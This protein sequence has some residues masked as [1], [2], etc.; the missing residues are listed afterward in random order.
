MP[1]LFAPVSLSHVS[2]SKASRECGEHPWQKAGREMTEK[3]ICCGRQALSTASIT[4][5]KCCTSL[6]RIS[7][8]LLKFG[9]LYRDLIKG[10]V[11]TDLRKH[12]GKSLIDLTEN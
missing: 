5:T 7:F 10:L 11:N 8:F 12:I 6:S 3:R 1:S 2:F 4:V 9:R